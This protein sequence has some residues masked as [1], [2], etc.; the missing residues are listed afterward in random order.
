MIKRFLTAIIVVLV[1]LTSCEDVELAPDSN[2][3]VKRVN[4]SNHSEL[5]T[6]YKG[7]NRRSKF[8]RSI[9]Q[10]VE[11]ENI[12]EVSDA[13]EA[14]YSFF[15]RDDKPYALSNLIIRTDGEDSESYIQEYLPSYEWLNSDQDW[16]KFSGVINMYDLNFNLLMSANLSNGQ[17]TGSRYKKS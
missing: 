1:F 12:I 5:S 17:S 6:I 10:L 8:G 14:Y 15:I 9:E 13:E 2:I 3:T 4:L 16:L 11:T 7:L